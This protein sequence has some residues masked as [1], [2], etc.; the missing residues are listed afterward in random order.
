VTLTSIR[1]FDARHINE[2]LLFFRSNTLAAI[3]VDARS[4]LY[5]S[6]ASISA[7]EY[8]L[9]FAIYRRKR[10]AVQSVHPLPKNNS[11]WQ[12]VET[13]AGYSSPIL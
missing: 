8:V 6:I 13:F 2:N 10:A 9:N 3:L 12:T 4:P 11:F 7:F 5:Y 1:R